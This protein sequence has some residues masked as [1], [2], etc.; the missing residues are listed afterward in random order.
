MVSRALKVFLR[1]WLTNNSLY[2]ML[3]SISLGSSII[4]SLDSI[5]R[6]VE[7]KDPFKKS[8]VQSGHE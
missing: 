6:R 3:V 1:V 5:R 8:L 7:F 4:L 2:A